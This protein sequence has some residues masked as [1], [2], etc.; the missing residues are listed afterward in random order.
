[1]ILFNYVFVTSLIFVVV[2]VILHFFTD[3]CTSRVSSRLYAQGKLG[4]NT[5]PN[6]GFFSVIGFD[7]FLHYVCLFGTYILMI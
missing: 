6:L 3:W 1:M 5:I 7:Q 2:N 4:S